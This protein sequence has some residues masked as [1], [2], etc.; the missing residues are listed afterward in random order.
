[1]ALPSADSAHHDLVII[2]SGSG[3][4][5]VTPDLEHLDIA[6]VE[7]GIGTRDAYGGTC[8]NV[9]CIPTKMLVYPADVVVTGRSAEHVDVT[10]SRP[11]ID[12]TSLQARV[13]GRVD[14]IADGGRAYR[15]S[16]ERVTL[17]EG[18]ARVVGD[19]ELEV[20]MADGSQVRVTAD[21][22]V[23]AAGSRPEMQD[24]PG[25]DVE[26]PAN[27]VHTS[28][29]IM[30]VS[31]PPQRLAIIGGG[32][33]GVEMAHMFDGAGSAVTQIVR[34]DL[35]LR[36]HDEPIGRIVTEIAA[37]RYDVCL[38]TTVVG[39]QRAGEVWE[40]VLMGPEGESVHEV[41]AV[42]VATGRRPNS[43][44]LGLP[45][46]GIELDAHGHV[47]VDEYLRASAENVWALGDV[48]NELQLKH[49]ANHEARTIAHNLA[50]PD[51]QRPVDHRFVPG[52]VFGNPQVATFGP[53]RAQLDAAGTRYVAKSQNFRDVAYGWAMGDAEG[54]LNVYADPDSGRLLAAHAVG[55]QASLVLQPL[56][57][58]ASFGQHVHD[59][60]RGQYWPHPSLAEVAENAL[61]GLDVTPG[62]LV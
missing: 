5:L 60:A 8:L 27:G 17:Y 19:R 62:R 1:M 16:A 35:L 11:E 34:G 14:A 39:A 56:I 22:L 13:F 51:D 46:G 57:A 45:A 26:D 7:R 47:K 21:R 4:S 31:A 43:D 29:T 28:D 20:S 15:A 42:L 18:T 12:W 2:G 55:Y 25:L 50:H 37:G 32:Y 24:V 59:A 58:I 10:P 3:N 9:G 48:A 38:N 40:L 53:T 6:I 30:R 54:V 23:L 33:I 52:V 36:H 61:L 44:L 41:D 49:V